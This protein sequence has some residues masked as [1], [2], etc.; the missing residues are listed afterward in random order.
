MKILK[1]VQGVP[2][3]LMMIPL[4]LGAGINTF[5]PQL[6]NMGSFTTALFSNKGSATILALSMFFV[7]TSFEIKNGLEV[8]KRGTVLLLVKVGFGAAMGLLM[9][10]LFGDAGFLGIST[11]AVVSA[12]TSSNTSLYMTLVNEYGEDTDVLAQSILNLGSGPFVAMAVFGSSGLA[13]VPL[14]DIISTMGPML[15]GIL[16]GNIDRDIREFLKPGITLMI[17]SVGFSIGVTMNLRNMIIGGPSGIVLGL[18]VI[19]GTGIPLI[20]FDRLI[21]GRQGYAGAAL[22]SVAGNA[23][24]TPA[25]I[26]LSDPKLIPLAQK[27]TTQIAAAVIVTIICTPLLTHIIA[28]RFGCEKKR[29][30][31]AS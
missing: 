1:R 24:F 28:N 12:A 27:A 3:G 8:M 15:V 6:I 13:G 17:P 30:V 9:N 29:E 25:V 7:G 23:V 5:F 26:A 4:F 21:N 16:V 31:M 20:I 11:L 2:G 14:K 18:I 10:R 19:L 22:S